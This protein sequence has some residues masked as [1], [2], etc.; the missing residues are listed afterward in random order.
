MAA[1]GLE[2]RVSRKGVGWILWVGRRR[3]WSVLGWKGADG[4]G[5]VVVMVGLCWWQQPWW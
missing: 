1:G 3:R 5:K 4:G 2:S